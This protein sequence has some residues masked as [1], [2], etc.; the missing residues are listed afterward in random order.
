MTDEP[1]VMNRPDPRLVPT[2]TEVIGLPSDAP[3][4]TA[5]GGEAVA[6]VAPPPTVAAAPAPSA[7]AVARR[8][9]A[10]LGPELDQRIAEAI[11]RALHAQM[12]GL[13]ARVRASVAE[14]VREAVTDT[15]RAAPASPE[16]SRNPDSHAG[17][18]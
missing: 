4:W 14:V 16:N 18:T 11:A 2:L 5:P 6:P 9:L 12:L 8:V 13:S 7:D 10:Q 15:L 1:G 3:S 17:P